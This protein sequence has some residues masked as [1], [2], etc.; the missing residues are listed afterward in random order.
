MENRPIPP[1]PRA[2]DE[3]LAHTREFGHEA[4]RMAN[5]TNRLAYPLPSD[6]SKFSAV[7]HELTPSMPR[8][9][10]GRFTIVEAGDPLEPIDWNATCWRWLRPRIDGAFVLLPEHFPEPET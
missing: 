9:V 1:I 4:D 2:Q 5:V 8:D 3:L 10:T 7:L 6:H